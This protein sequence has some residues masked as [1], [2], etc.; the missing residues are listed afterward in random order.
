MTTKI[1]SSQVSFIVSTTGTVKLGVA[2]L[3]N[4]SS[5][6]DNV[7]VG[8]Y[9]LN[10]VT[11]QSYNVA[12]GTSAGVS[13][14]SANNTLLGYEAG[15]G[16]TTGANNTIIGSL[17]ALS[18]L[19]TGSN[20]I[21]IGKG[22]APSGNVSNEITLGDTSIT[23]F[24]VPGAAYHLFGTTTVAALPAAAAGYTGARWFVTDSNAAMTA[25]IGAVVA[26]GGANKVPV[27]CD[28]TNWRIG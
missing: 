14:T 3:S 19:T 9:A 12:V 15:M 22:A 28:G 2:N 5:G 25:G 18:A 24:R 13:L 27:F 8:E 21:V 10:Q 26:A 7:A 6:T 17:A 1:N 23:A 16:L 20:N 11:T 4:L